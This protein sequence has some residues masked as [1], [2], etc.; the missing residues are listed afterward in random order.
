MDNS[1]WNMYVFRDG[2]RTVSGESLHSRLLE[3]IRDCSGDRSEDNCVAALIAAGDLECA[4]ADARSIDSGPVAEITDRLADWLVT[5][6]AENIPALALRAGTLRIPERVS[7][8]IPE[9]FAYYALHPRKFIDLLRRLDR[10]ETA[11]VIGLRTI[12]TTLSAVAAA[13]LRA[14]RVPCGRMTVRPSGHPYDRKFSFAENEK[15]RLLGFGNARYF[16]VDEGPGISGSSFLAVA[17]A[18]ESAGVPCNNILLIGSREPDVCQLRAPSADER[19]PRFQFLA[20]DPRPVLPDGAEIDIGGGYWR[21]T[22][23]HDF[24]NQPAC[25]TQLEAAKYVSSDRHSLYKFHGYGHH[26]QALAA[27]AA[28]LADS[29]FAPH[30]SRVEKGFGIY[31]FTPGRILTVSDLNLEVLARLAEYCAF[32]ALRFPAQATADDLQQML[33]WNWECEFGTKLPMTFALPITRPVL[34]DGRMLPHEWLCTGDGRLLKLDGISHGDDHFFPGPCDIAW[35]L[36][37]VIIEW[38]MSR[39]ASTE[40]LA[41]YQ[42]LS[43][44]NPLDRLPNYLLAYAVFRMAWSKMAA[45]ASAGS[46]D[47]GLLLRD[48]RRYRATAEELAQGLCREAIAQGDSLSVAASCRHSLADSA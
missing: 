17:E 19:W 4:L 25:W 22:L 11:Y 45:Q 10:P 30:I 35:D 29:G 18:L 9:G 27:R 14:L 32:R 13:T 2:R 47:E 26:G 15:A 5:G 31:D 12:G 33:A 37:G 46:F 38:Q 43:R 1:G 8:S 16:I 36:A 20:V 40:F 21:Q 42:Q 7:I 48:Y 28:K 3:A 23:L 6:L 44:D 39:E 34:S 24:E 41:R